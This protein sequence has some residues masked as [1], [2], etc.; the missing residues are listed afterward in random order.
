M[1]APTKSA[2]LDTRVLQISP[3]DNIAAAVVT[4]KKGDTITLQGQA[5]TVP[6][7]VPRGHKLAIVPIKAGTK[8][9][10]YGAPIGTATRDIAA[11]EYVHSHNLKSDYLPPGGRDRHTAVQEH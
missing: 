6:V 11:G 4:L 5:V 2:A 10:K 7:D 1:V 9:L 8:I 3:E